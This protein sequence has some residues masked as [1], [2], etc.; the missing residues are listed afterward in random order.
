[1]SV[2]LKIKWEGDAPGVQEGRLSLAGFGQSLRILLAALRRIATNLVRDAID[3]RES[4]VGRFTNAARQLDIEITELVKG[5][6]GFDSIITLKTPLGENLPLFS[7]LPEI[8]GVQLLDALDSESHG[9]ARNAP[10][11]AFLKALPLGLA[12]Q[13]YQLHRNGTVLKETI[14]GE[15]QLPDFAADLPYLA[16]YKGSV[17]GVGFE[18]GRFEVR[19]RTRTGPIVLLATA[20]QV[21]MALKLRRAEI[22]ARAVVENAR[23][24]LL[25]IQ[26]SDLPLNRSTRESAIYDRWRVLLSR[27]AQ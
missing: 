17:I 4:T 27:L 5:S 25:F 9:V 18:P 20:E 16:S 3:Q 13:T 8:A 19:I 23:N 11:R 6:S 26:P 2:E 1:M 7:D 10:V 15:L 24:R 21:E 22:I 12:R 14:V